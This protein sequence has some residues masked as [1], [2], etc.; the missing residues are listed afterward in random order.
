MMFTNPLEL[1]IV[2][3]LIV[4]L[5]TIIWWWFQRVVTSLD[6]SSK[7][8]QELVISVTK[9]CGTMATIGQWQV[10]HEQTDVSRYE[11]HSEDIDRLADTVQQL[12]LRSA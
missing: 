1:A 7:Q 5:G 2:S 9:I 10:L 3:G 6:R 12:S 11:A 4:A 8:Q